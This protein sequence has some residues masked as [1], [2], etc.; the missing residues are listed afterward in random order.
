[1]ERQSWDHDSVFSSDSQEEK[2]LKFE[3]EIECHQ[4]ALT[5]A[6]E[7]KKEEHT[8]KANT[9]LGDVYFINNRFHPFIGCYTKALEVAKDANDK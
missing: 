5:L 2:A 9:A 4:R 3:M 6:S 1:M 7:E 8:W